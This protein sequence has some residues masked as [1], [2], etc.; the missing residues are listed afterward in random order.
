MWYNV[1]EYVKYLE[2][3]SELKTKFS[4]FQ[5]PKNLFFLFLMLSRTANCMVA[6]SL[7]EGS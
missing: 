3:Y 2:F 6:H 5:I 7:E 4:S 1:K